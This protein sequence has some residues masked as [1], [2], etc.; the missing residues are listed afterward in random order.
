VE[1]LVCE[2]QDCSMQLYYTLIDGRAND[3]RGRVLDKGFLI[4]EDTLFAG[5][6][7]AM[8][9]INGRDWWVIVWKQ[10]SNEYVS[11]LV[12]EDGAEVQHREHIGDVMHWKSNGST[13]AVFSPDGTKYAHFSARSGL[14]LYDFDRETG[15]LS[16]YRSLELEFRHAYGGCVFAPGSR[17]LYI[18]D[19]IRMYQVDTWQEDLEVGLHRLA[20][21]DWERGVLKDWFPAPYHWGQ[22]GPDC[23]IYYST[24]FVDS[25]LHVI[26]KPDEAGEA[27]ELEQFS[28]IYPFRMSYTV[29][30]FPH[31]RIG[32]EAELHCEIVNTVQQVTTM[33]G[34]ELSIWPNPAG[35]VVGIALPDE[36]I[37]KATLRIYNMSGSLMRE[38]RDVEVS[39]GTIVQHIPGLG[40]GMYLLECIAITGQRWTA[41]FVVQ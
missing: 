11:V 27:C 30:N 35:N 23:K 9:H 17:Y 36:S 41:R 40:A 8:R 29:P 5:M 1:H 28:I 3:G 24:G 25:I 22:L 39:S 33:K 37:Y 38:Q 13:Q 2:Q 4:M 7:T 18:N 16:R 10:D 34:S 21:Y 14:F 19:N 32:E 20:D 6:V 12:T 31:F 26:H 15:Y